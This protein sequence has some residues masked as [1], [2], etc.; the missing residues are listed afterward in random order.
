MLERETTIIK[1]SH[2][3]DQARLSLPWHWFTRKDK[4]GAL[5]GPVR[6]GDALTNYATNM[7]VT[8]IDKPQLDLYT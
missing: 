7:I 1:S 2:T 4:L 5:A 6:V 3:K 8:G